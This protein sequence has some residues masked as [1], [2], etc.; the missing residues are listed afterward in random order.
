M[1][2]IVSAKS[3]SIGNFNLPC[4]SYYWIR[5]DK[6]VWARPWTREQIADAWKADF[7][8][9]LSPE[10]ARSEAERLLDFFAQFEEGVAS[11]QAEKTRTERPDERGL[12]EAW[13]KTMER[14]TK[15]S[16]KSVS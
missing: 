16:R 10:A 14:R 15:A 2:A 13:E 4:Q 3:L 12:R 9:I 5:A 1:F 7:N 6:I 8:E 11:T